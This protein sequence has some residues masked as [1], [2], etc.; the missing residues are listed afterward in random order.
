M[1]T[2]I[3]ILSL[4]LSLSAG[5]ANFRYSYV[6]GATITVNAPDLGVHQ[7][8]VEDWIWAFYAPT[9]TDPQSPT[10]GQTL[11]RTGANLAEAW[12][13]WARANWRGTAAEIRRWKQDQDRAA[14]SGPA[15]PEE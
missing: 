5:A 11:P 9:D 1:R 15:V 12:R 3:L 8:V 2:T 14:I 13:N 6:A 7:Q 4:L 10:F